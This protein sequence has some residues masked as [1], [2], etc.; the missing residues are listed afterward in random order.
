MTSEAPRRIVLGIG[1]PD[2][3]D[4]AAGRAVV[5]LLRGVLPADIELAEHSGEASALLSRLEGASHAFLIDAS[6]SGAPAGTIRRFDVAARPL[7]Q[8]A[9]G[10]STHGFG[11]VEAV[12]LAR[13]LGRLP[14][15]CVLYAIEAASFAVGAPLS[16]D[17]RA[18][19]AEVARL[20]SKEVRELAAERAISA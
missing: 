16:G 18:A 13:A 12:G 14:P 7:P 6:A 10:L 5:A 20:L 8:G 2:R 15:R 17:V 4:D 9:S 1:N 3:G 11:V 19:V